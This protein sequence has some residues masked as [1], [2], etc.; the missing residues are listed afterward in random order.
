MRIK[1]AL[2][3][4]YI[5][6]NE[7]DDDPD[8]WPEIKD[9]NYLSFKGVH[10]VQVSTNKLESLISE[11]NSD[12]KAFPNCVQEVPIHTTKK[13]SN[14]SNNQRQIRFFFG[15][16]NRANDWEPYIDTINQFI[17]KAGKSWEFDIIHDRDFFDALQTKNKRFTPTCK[18]ADYMKR[19]KESHVAFLPLALNRFNSYKSDLKFV[20]SSSVCTVSIASPTVYSEVISHGNTGYLFHGKETLIDCLNKIDANPDEAKQIALNAQ[21]WVYHNRLISSQASQRYDWYMSL[22]NKKSELTAQLLARIP[23]L[24]N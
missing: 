11:H 13:W 24:A 6:I 21:N 1:S 5:L 10:A 4:G 23:E 9:N 2:N 14:L 19:L 15:A 20:E 17:E 7:Y 8:H 16:L 18:Y 3:A 22:W 12:C